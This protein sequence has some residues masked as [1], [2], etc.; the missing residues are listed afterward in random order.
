MEKSVAGW[1]PS[2]HVLVTVCKRPAS[3]NKGVKSQRTGTRSR[4]VRQPVRIRCQVPGKVV[5]IAERVWSRACAIRW[6]ALALT[7]QTSHHIVTKHRPQR[8]VST[9]GQRGRGTRP[10]GSDAVSTGLSVA[11]ADFHSRRRP[12]KYR[13]G[14]KKSGYRLYHSNN[15]WKSSDSGDRMNIVSLLPARQSCCTG[16]VTSPAHRLPLVR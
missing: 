13:T 4:R 2:L 10:C 1:V 16:R 15:S 12:P 5:A 7:L 14:N 8:D 9:T 3:S 11:Q 6:G